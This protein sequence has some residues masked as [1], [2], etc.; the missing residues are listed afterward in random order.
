MKRNSLASCWFICL[1]PLILLIAS[2]SWY[3]V[4]LVDAQETADE[5]SDEYYY[6]EGAGKEK[7]SDLW[8]VSSTGIPIPD[9]RPLIEANGYIRNAGGGVVKINR[10]LIDEAFLNFTRDNYDCLLGIDLVVP[11]VEANVT[12]DIVPTIDEQVAAMKVKLDK[13]L[14]QATRIVNGEEAADPTEGQ[15]QQQGQQQGQQ[16]NQGT[17]ATTSATSTDQGLSKKRLSFREK[18][19]LR[20]QERKLKDEQREMVKPKFRLGADCETLVCGSCKAIV[21]EFATLVHQNIRNPNIKYI[22]QLTQGFCDIKQIALKY[23][24]IV[25]DICRVFDQVDFYLFFFLYGYS[26]PVLFLG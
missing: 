18:Q 17:N 15:Q 24:G 2:S 14:K 19:A 22:D 5:Y 9:D 6:E 3:S 12:E 16:G 20:Q 25:G 4:R 10:Y 23:K 1:L 11:V 8:E 7:D 13:A 21:E 26:I